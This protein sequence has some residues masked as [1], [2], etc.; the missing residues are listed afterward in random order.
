MAS[1]TGAYP[2][3]TREILGEVHVGRAA[4]LESGADTLLLNI[5]VLGFETYWM[6]FAFNSGES[7]SG[8]MRRHPSPFLDDQSTV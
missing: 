2:K 5:Q 8:K 6:C 3:G 7:S 1:P 4:L